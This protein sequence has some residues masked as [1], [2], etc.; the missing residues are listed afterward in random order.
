MDGAE[1]S[2][3]LERI[4]QLVR[5][6]NRYVEERAPWSLARDPE[7][8]DALDRTLASLA[9]GLRVLS[10]LLSPYLPTSTAT[11]LDALRAPD[12]S[13]AAAEFRPTGG[14]RTVEAIEPLFPKMSPAT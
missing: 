12:V 14:G 6:C 7:A 5:R 3:A 2:T 1:A 8:A 11:L 13:L 4:W 9:E 10:V